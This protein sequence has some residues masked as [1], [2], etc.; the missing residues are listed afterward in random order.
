MHVV[1]R[2]AWWNLTVV[3]DGDVS[4][5]GIG[6]ATAI[7]LPFVHVQN[8]RYEGSDTTGREHGV[9]WVSSLEAHSNSIKHVR[10]EQCGR[11]RFSLASRL[12]RTR[13][14][15]TQLLLENTSLKRNESFQAP[16]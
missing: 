8:L 12:R 7:L 6:E 3:Y 2:T 13:E 14:T 15:T 10:K 4:C 1:E 16:V 5:D 9:V 11:S